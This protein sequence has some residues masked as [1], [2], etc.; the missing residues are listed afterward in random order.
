V[1]LT[2]DISEQSVGTLSP[3]RVPSQTTLNVLMVLVNR[4]DGL[5]YSLPK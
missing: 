1:F 5:V 2:N 3:P 4:E